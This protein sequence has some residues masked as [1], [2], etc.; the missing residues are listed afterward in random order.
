MK[1]TKAGVA[2]EDESSDDFFTNLDK[3]LT[4]ARNRGGQKEADRVLELELKKLDEKDKVNERNRLAKLS[5]DK[6]LLGY[7]ADFYKQFP[8][9]PYVLSD[10][11]LKWLVKY[12]YKKF[13]D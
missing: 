4:E 13:V 10:T 1:P 2:D 3:A 7:W 11:E 6:A 9:V 8:G 5:T 12:F